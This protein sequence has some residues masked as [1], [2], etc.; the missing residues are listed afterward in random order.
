M[1]TL[2]LFNEGKRL[3]A[4]GDSLLG[5]RMLEEASA[6]G[7]VK[8]SAFLGFGFYVGRDGLPCNKEMAEKYLNV[9]ISQASPNNRDLS[10]AHCF[11]GCIYYFGEAGKKD[12]KKAISHFKESAERENMIGAY[13]HNLATSKREDRI[14]K[15]VL[16]PVIFLIIIVAALISDSFGWN[17]NLVSVVITGII[18]LLILAYISNCRKYWLKDAEKQSP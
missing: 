18:L 4:L 2:S 11:L 1:S 17:E 10:D 16:M 6:A 5:V 8:A 9:F 14:L 15:W 7:S 3:I 12:L 13:Y